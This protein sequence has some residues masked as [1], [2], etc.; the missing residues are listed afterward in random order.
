[1]GRF[2]TVVMFLFCAYGGWSQVQTVSGTVRST[3]GEPLIGATILLKGTGRGTATDF[4]GRYSLALPDSS[5]VLLFS[6]TGMQPQTITVAGRSRVDVLLR[7]DVQ[8]ID[9]VVVTAYTGEQKQRDIVGSYE[10]VSGDELLPQRPVESFDKMLDGQIAGVQV[11]LNTGE[12]GLPVQVRIRGNNSLPPV[13]SNDVVA[14]G[15]PLFVLDGVPLYDVSETNTANTPFSTTLDQQ[16]NPLM[17][18]RP[19]DIESIT[20]LKDASATAI[21][22]ANAANGVILI[23]TKQGKAGRTKITGGVST[24]FSRLINPVRYLDTEEYVSLARETLFNSGG[25]PEDAGPI[26]VE[27]DWPALTQRQGSVTNASLSL[28]GGND[29]TK[30]YLSAGYF[31]ENAISRG[32]GLERITLRSNLN[33]GLSDKLSLRFGFSGGYVY[34]ASFSD[35]GAF[36]YPPN[37]SPFNADG[38]FNNGG[39][40]INRPNPLAALAQNEFFHHA[41]SVNNNLQLTYEPVPGLQLR[42]MGGIDGYLQLQYQ[43]FSALNGSGRTVN[44]RGRRFTRGNLQ[45]VANAQ[46][47]YQKAFAE[48]HLSALAGTEANQQTTYRQRITASNFPSDQLREF[49]T[50]DVSDIDADESNYQDATQSFYAQASYDYAYRY[51][52]T[53]SARRDASSIFG[54]DVQAG[55]FF[56]A[57]LAWAFSE[58]AALAEAGWLSFGKLRFSY[59]LT[60]NSR[61]GTYSARGL[62]GYSPAYLYGGNIGL[63]PTAPANESLTWELVRKYN[64]AIDL[65]FLQGRLK[66]TV[67]HYRNYTEDAIYTIPVPLESGFAN[68]VTNAA[69][70]RNVGWEASIQTVNIQGELRWSTRFN[71][72]RNRNQLTRIDAERFPASTF[73]SRGLVVGENSSVL[74]GVPFAG[75]DPYNGKQLFFL[76]DGSITDDHRL[77]NE[78]EN[79]VPVGQSAPD[80][81]GGVSNTFSYKGLTL[82]VLVSYSYG[83]DVLVDPLTFT[84]GRQILINNQSAN[85][86]DRWQ[87]P[88]DLTDTPRLHQSTPIQRN[89]T[90]YLFDNDFLRLANASLQYQLPARWLDAIGITRLS[91]Q[92]QANNL[93]YLYSTRARAGRNGVA[94]YRFR[95]PEA[96]AFMF[97]L[98][99]TL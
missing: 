97:G 61:L 16:L 64:F 86:L 38:S 5:A 42:A 73:N 30:F 59:G 49:W 95:F 76:P 93:G 56:S 23:T 67:E 2:A 17:F 63:A 84:D 52:F 68:I 81:Y 9:E 53:V 20:V 21:Y 71:I 11:E 44:G 83:E 88:G 18:V 25:N 39:F 57:G 22:G 29:K 60:G 40:F 48:H 98:N 62:Y 75:I 80:W 4:E 91:V 70:Q 72:A 99:L 87:Q 12:P 85:Q 32:N 13:N 28:N 50:V 43:Y 79:W 34:K 36:T 1:M 82:D 27:T 10:Q 15:Q 66:A 37:Q 74:Y 26:D 33:T 65:E 47:S 94:A 35:F 54:G 89:N 6:Y 7:E 58:E 31:R 19:E 78:P 41:Y 90:R 8:M 46:A 92:A 69:D 55:N 96:Q 45:W 77:L 51:Y 14:S 3:S 24:G